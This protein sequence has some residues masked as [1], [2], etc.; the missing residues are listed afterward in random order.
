MP[1]KKVEA[2]AT[3]NTQTVKYLHQIANCLAYLVVQTGDLKNKQKGDL[4][5]VLADFGFD[6]TAIAAILDTTPESVSARISQIKAESKGK[7]ANETTPDE[8]GKFRRNS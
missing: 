3:E 1:S 2:E 4:M 8:P 7:K 6:R 5:M